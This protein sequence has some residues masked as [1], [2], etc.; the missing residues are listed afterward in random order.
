[1]KIKAN[2]KELQELNVNTKIYGIK[3]IMNCNQCGKRWAIWFEGE[4]DLVNNLP[5]DFY[6]CSTCTGIFNSRGV[7]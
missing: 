7:K 1:M 6:R 2:N 5:E 3:L 4:D